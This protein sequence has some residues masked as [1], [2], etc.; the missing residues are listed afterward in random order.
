[1]NC[2]TAAAAWRLKS[3]AAPSC[4]GATTSGQFLVRIVWSGVAVALRSVY[5]MADRVVAAEFQDQPAPGAFVARIREAAG[6]AQDRRDARER[7][8]CL[9]QLGG[10]EDRLAGAPEAHFGERHHLDHAL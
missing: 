2:P 1:M 6:A 8:A 10:D 9:R 4:G 5:E 3:S 7:R